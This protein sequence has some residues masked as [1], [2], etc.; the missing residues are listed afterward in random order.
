MREPRL[1]RNDR[2]IDRYRNSGGSACIEGDVG[3][4][5]TMFTIRDKR[6]YFICE[7]GITSAQMADQIDPERTNPKIP[8]VVQSPE[9]AYGATTPSI[10]RTLCVGAELFKQTYLPETVAQDDLLE[11]ALE[12]AH[13]LAGV[14]D[15]INTLT[16][17]VENLKRRVEAG[18]V[19]MH[20]TPKTPALNQTVRGSIA[21][22]HKFVVLCQKLSDLF[23]QRAHN[24]RWS[25]HLRTALAAQLK[26]DD[27]NWAG[28]DWGFAVVKVITNARNAMIHIDDGDK[29]LIVR[30]YQLKPDGT[31]Q[32][33]TIEVIHP[34]IAPE[35]PADVLVFLTAYV[36]ELSKLFEFYAVIFCDMNARQRP[37]AFGS[38]V[39]RTDEDRR[40]G[41]PYFWHT[42]PL[43]GFSLGLQPEPEPQPEG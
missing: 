25:D 17:H 35:P 30:D 19:P 42:Y 6:M 15:Q 29:D 13:L 21:D 11:I 22:F 33:P 16:A 31:L 9:M 40:T 24:A 8:K 36:D 32:P 28:L 2:P 39:A 4:I 14:Q 43:P 26:P 23:Y 5:L 7:R 37:P 27:A 10:Q 3:P 38:A 12:A 34:E 1:D 18:E 41:T 20:V